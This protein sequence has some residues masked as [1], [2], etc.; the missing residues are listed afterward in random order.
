MDI[1]RV[2]CVANK[3]FKT[4][5]RN[6]ILLFLTL[7]MAGLAI[8]IAYFGSASRGQVGF[9]IGGATIVSLVS[10][11]TYIIPIIALVLGHDLI[12]GEFE[13]RTLQ[14]ML[15]LPVSKTEI[16]IGKF[17]GQA[18]SIM[19][20]I[21]FGFGLVGLFL[22]VSMDM[23][24]LKDFVYLI[25]SSNLLGLCFLA[26]SQ[27]SSA[28]VLQRVKSIGLALFFWFFFV[29]I[30]DLL[31]ISLLVVTEGNV[32]S[33]IFSYLLFLNPTDIF[34]VINLFGIEEAKGS[35]GLITLAS[36]KSYIFTAYFAFTLWIILPLTAGSYLFNRKEY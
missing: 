19:F 28:I 27:L 3:E 31:L 29:L 35:F 7:L 5:I 12:V 18:L 30:F 33:S 36:N 24:A 26:L 17:L 4:G 22:A 34:R 14:L 20:S 1:N 2:L 9:D 32:D 13:G 21:T 25:I 23:S 15:T 10:L 6:K 16:Y 8:T 11:S